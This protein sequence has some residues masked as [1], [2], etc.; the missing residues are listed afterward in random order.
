MRCCKLHG[1]LQSSAA[2]QLLKGG[3]AAPAQ[4]HFVVACA[5]SAGHSCPTWQ[6]PVCGVPPIRNVSAAFVAWMALAQVPQPVRGCYAGHSTRPGMAATCRSGLAASC[7]GLIGDIEV[8]AGAAG[9]SLRSTAI[10]KDLH[11]VLPWLVCVLRADEHS[12]AAAVGASVWECEDSRP[13]VRWQFDCVLR[14]LC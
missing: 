5:S 12:P 6:Q 1:G 10:D 14:C 2:S 4:V 13:F 11:A 9:W 8:V 7:R 3:A